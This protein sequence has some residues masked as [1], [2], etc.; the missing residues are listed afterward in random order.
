M[1][2]PERYAWRVLGLNVLVVSQPALSAGMLNLALPDLARRTGASA[3]QL[4][5]V[6]SVYWLVSTVLLLSFGRLADMLGRRRLYVG[7]IAVFTLASAG[8]ALATSA[9]VL[10]AWRVGQAVGAAAIIVN[11]S[12]LLTD[13]FPPRLLSTG[14]GVSASIF[15][16]FGLAGPVAGGA[17]ASGFGG[18]AVFWFS[19]PFGAV[20]LVGALVLLRPHRAAAGRQPF[21]VPGAAV[22]AAALTA[23]VVA[24]STGRSWG[25]GSPRTVGLLALSAAAFVVFVLIERRRRHPL[26]DLGLF[27]VWSRSAAYFSLALLAVSDFS[28]ALLMSLYFQRVMK[29]T[30]LDAGLRLLPITLATIVAAPA[31][32]RLASRYSSQV[33]SSCGLGL[34]AVA[35]LGLALSF[36]ARP[37]LLVTSACL[38]TI[39]IGSAL[40]MTPN[41]HAIMSSVTADRRSIAN[42][43]R[44]TIQN[45]SGL[46]GNALVLAI[47]AAPAIATRP[48]AAPYRTATLVLITLC[49]AGTVL[50]LARGSRHE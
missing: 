41:N 44:S 46:T 42:A 4:T 33:L 35:L 22:S 18:Q 48:S 40:F 37:S 25:W 6:V 8:C 30:A 11:S 2:A 1:G 5:L 50:S 36:A 31:A 13:A 23:L 39:G 32:G 24:L 29:L 16:A 27:A 20:G 47:V 26:L 19:V 43:V 7:G 28:I 9:D 38:A 34:H 49:T 12:A 21:D 10:I 45:A 3:A 14:M 17:L 15:S